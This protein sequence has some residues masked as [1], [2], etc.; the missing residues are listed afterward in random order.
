MPTIMITCAS[1]GLGSA[2]ELAALMAWLLSPAATRV[3]G[4]VWSLD[5]GFSTIRPPVK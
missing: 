4:Q 2:A 5:G 1:G 3:T